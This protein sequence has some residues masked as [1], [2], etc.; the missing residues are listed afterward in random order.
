MHKEVL[1]WFEDL[2]V[3]T[4]T[5]YIEIESFNLLVFRA[6]IVRQFFEPV[7]LLEVP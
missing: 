3:K 5:S 4:K 7:T 2:S 1:Q 6:W